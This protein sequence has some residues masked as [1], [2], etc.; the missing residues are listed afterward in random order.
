MR[1]MNQTAPMPLEDKMIAKHLEKL[2]A[3]SKTVAGLPKMA[4]IDQEGNVT[5]QL[6]M[7]DEI[8]T[9]LDEALAKLVHDARQIKMT[10]DAIHV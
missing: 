10:I 9:S 7:V 6:Q 1:Q 3:L 2:E 4:Q 8:T 5:K